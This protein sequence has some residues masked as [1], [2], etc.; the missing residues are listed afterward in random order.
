MRR[1]TTAATL[2]AALMIAAPTRASERTV[3]VLLFDGF[4]PALLEH[5]ETPA[6]ARM[7]SEGAWT[8]DLTP[9]FPSISLPNQVS[10]STGCWPEHHGIVSNE[11]IDPQRGAYDHSHDTDWLTGCEHLHQAAE[12]QGVHA[13]VLGWVGRYSE[14]KGDMATAVSLE[15]KHAEYPDDNK[16]ADQVLQ[17][18]RMPDRQRPRLILAYFH[19]PDDEE[20]FTGMNSA[21]TQKAVATSDAC[22][23]RILDGINALPFRNDVTLIVTTDH[24]M[25]PVSYNVNVKKILLNHEINARFVSS[26]T[27]SFLYFDD[28]REA[29]RTVRELNGYPQ[30]NV[31]RKAIQPPDWHIGSG[32]RVGDLIIS[33]KPPYFIEDIGHWPWWVQWLGTF[34]PEFIWSGFALKASHG[35]PP[36]V[37][38][39]EG[40]LYAWGAGIAKGKEVSGLRAIDV[41]PTV[42]QLLGIKPGN[43]VDGQVARE[44]LAE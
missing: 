37:P 15:R 20:H 31:V 30:F 32:P 28:P 29:E 11:F 43:P 6:L 10:I 35:Y 18:L 13:A 36:D 16:R 17:M 3:V 41:H 5:S 25:M 12:R 14:T 22:V 42:A 1:L 34:G 39:V 33:A 7:R 44:L 4:S 27:T 8:N 23:G 38:G 9:V 26:G 24:G 2:V 19:G 21:K 40:I